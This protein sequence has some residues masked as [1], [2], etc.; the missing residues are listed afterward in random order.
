MFLAGAR[1]GI[2]RLALRPMPSARGPLLVGDLT[3][4]RQNWLDRAIEKKIGS[5]NDGRIDGKR[6]PAYD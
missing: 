3:R 4:A 5:N 1:N 2:G 6:I